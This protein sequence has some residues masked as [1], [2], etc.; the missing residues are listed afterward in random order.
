MANYMPWTISQTDGVNTMEG[1]IFGKA[2]QTIHMISPME[3][4]STDETH[5]T[6]ISRPSA[7]LEAQDFRAPTDQPDAHQSPT[8]DSPEQ[9]PDTHMQPTC[10]AQI[11][12][13]EDNLATLPG[14]QS[15]SQSLTPHLLAPLHA[16]SILVAV[17]VYLLFTQ[18]FSSPEFAAPSVTNFPAGSRHG[19]E[20]WPWS[21]AQSVK[22][23]KSCS[24][25]ITAIVQ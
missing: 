24:G 22:S 20:E 6:N 11:Y 19:D 21:L 18:Q 9:V 13:F 15:T 1:G 14:P 10:L 2:L 5:P 25:W 3:T 16:L 23:V 7:A 12:P 4:K 17:M 8:Q